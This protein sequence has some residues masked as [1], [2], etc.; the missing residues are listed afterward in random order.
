MSQRRLSSRRDF[1]ARTA[2]A[3]FAAYAGAAAAHGATKI[4]PTV[5]L[6]RSTPPSADEP[7]RMAVIGTGGMGTGHCE[8]FCA[9]GRDGRANV[10]IV[11]L[12]DPWPANL[13]RARQKCEQGQTEVRVDAY[14]DYHQVLAREDIHAVLIASPEHWHAQHVIDAITAGK[15]VY[16][17]KPMTL[18][19]DQ[20]LE[21][22]RT[23]KAHPDRIFQVGTQKM[24]LPKY[25]EARKVIASGS[26]GPPTMSQ[27]SYCRNSKSGEWNYYHVDPNWKPGKDVD[28]DAWCG[29]LGQQPWDPYL[30]N[31]WRRYSVASTGIVGDLLV[32]EMT[33]LMFALQRGWPTRV[34]AQGQHIIDKSMDN[35]DTVNLTIAF[36]KE[37]TML[38]A[39]ATNN[40]VG[41][42]TLIRCHKGNIFLNSRHCVV[43]PE[44]L[45]VDDIE[46]Q[47][48]ECPD[49]GN[50]QDMH[51]LGWLESIRNREAPAA[52][53]EISTQVMVAVDLATRSMWSGQAWSFDPETMTA[54]PIC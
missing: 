52:G 50:D 23:V 42:E 3:G 8:A 27:T 44:R 9:F 46:E 25:H 7:V 30:L 35:H 28:W 4:R 6:G 17:E 1:L 11:A 19:L 16:C 13:N 31:R 20:A 29:P 51:R 34:I 18:R 48:I 33:P 36:E 14:A 37:H 2:A 40:E 43:R 38:V 5:R 21:V 12:A 53:I 10:Q 54:A 22:Y 39:G 45:F 24:R 47:T 26:L 41:L 49:I 32:H 15:D